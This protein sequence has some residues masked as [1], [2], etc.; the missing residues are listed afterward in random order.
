MLLVTKGIR[1]S[2]PSFLY[3]TPRDVRC[4]S[5]HADLQDTRSG[6]V[7][8]PV[9]D[10]VFD[11]ETRSASSLG[12]YASVDKGVSATVYSNCKS[13]KASRCL[14]PLLPVSTPAWPV[15]PQIFVPSQTQSQKRFFQVISTLECRDVVILQQIMPLLCIAA[16]WP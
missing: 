3:V 13:I 7:I 5:K 6:S 14:Y 9:Q 15:S 16:E 1:P 2:I 12:W 8:S 11:N 10:V 4:I